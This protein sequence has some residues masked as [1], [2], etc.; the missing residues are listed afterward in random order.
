MAVRLHDSLDRL[1]SLLEKTLSSDASDASDAECRALLRQAAGLVRS[2]KDI[3]GRRL[4]QVRAGAGTHVPLL[5]FMPASRRRRSPT[6]TCS[7]RLRSLPSAS[8]IS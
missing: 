5:G 7:H 3:S 4:K 2:A 1:T 8:P 6:P